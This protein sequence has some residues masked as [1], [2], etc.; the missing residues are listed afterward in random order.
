MRSFTPL[1]AALLLAATLVFPARANPLTIDTERRPV[2]MLAED[3]TVS[4]GPDVSLVKGT[5]RFAQLPDD[6]PEQPDR[7]VLIFVPVYLPRK[8]GAAVDPPV[9]KVGDRAIPPREWNDLATGDDPA[10]G[11]PQGGP[12]VL[13]SY[14]YAVP[15]ALVQREF[16][17]TVEYSQPSFPGH[18]AA[19][20]PLRPPTAPGAGRI[21]F[22][23]T[24][25]Y[26]LKPF[27]ARQFWQPAFPS[28][29]FAPRDRELLR[30]KCVRR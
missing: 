5:Y 13:K 19:Y 23:A 25:G 21:T 12:M 29:T 26:A 10:A 20:L 4:V 3:V 30:V 11:I 18:V 17:V 2:R 16:P 9:V 15:L 27:A 22:V 14:Q 8:G 7:H 6:F 24:P 28:L 1:L